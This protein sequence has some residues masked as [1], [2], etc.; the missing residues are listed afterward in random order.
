MSFWQLIA[1]GQVFK[2]TVDNQVVRGSTR[3]AKFY[4]HT[5]FDSAEVS[6][7]DQGSHPLFLI[8]V[9]IIFHPLS[10]RQNVALKLSSNHSS[11]IGV[12]TLNILFWKMKAYGL[13]VILTEVI[14][15]TE[16][17]LG[18]E[19]NCKIVVGSETNSLGNPQGFEN[20]SKW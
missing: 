14:F 7:F 13:D 1:Y 5:T 15:D 16:T 8:R 18:Q 17:L 3:G 2:R 10:G 4:A 12:L 19:K 6:L 20:W 9:K 11:L